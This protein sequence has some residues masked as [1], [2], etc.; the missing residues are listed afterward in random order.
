FGED[1]N[2]I[3][4]TTTPLGRSLQDV[5]PVINQRCKSPIPLWRFFKTRKD[6]QFD[7]SLEDIGH[8]VSGCIEKQ[9]ARLISEPNLKDS[10][11]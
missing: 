10:P 6:K 1:F 11:E 9:R 8:F 3:E 2:S 4:Q 5:F 7:A